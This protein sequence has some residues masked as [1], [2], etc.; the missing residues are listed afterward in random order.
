MKTTTT[1]TNNPTL[2]ISCD[3]DAQECPCTNTQV[4]IDMRFD[5]FSIAQ[6]D[7]ATHAVHLP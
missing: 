7:T 3:S 1:T 4:W 2:H 5:V 6:T